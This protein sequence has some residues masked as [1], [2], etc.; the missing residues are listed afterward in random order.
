[1]DVRCEILKKTSHCVFQVTSI[2]VVL[3]NNIERWGSR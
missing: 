2:F 1:M 3:I